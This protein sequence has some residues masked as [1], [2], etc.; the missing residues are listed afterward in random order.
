MSTNT[1][2][3]QP[4]KKTGRKRP[5]PQV[6][7]AK[8]EVTLRGYV[9]MNERVREASRAGQALE[10]WRK[11]VYDFE[12]E[13]PDD[14]EIPVTRRNNFTLA[15]STGYTI[16]ARTLEARLRKEALEEAIDRSGRSVSSG[17]STNK[18]GDA[19]PPTGDALKGDDTAQQGA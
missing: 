10:D 19:T 7:N 8:S 14:V 17:D 12:G 11:G 9:D 16:R 6:F 18:R 13:V 15:D 2:W 4:D 1:V 3:T 5:L